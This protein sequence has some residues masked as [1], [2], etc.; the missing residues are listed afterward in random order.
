MYTLFEKYEVRYQ[1]DLAKNKEICPIKC[2]SRE[3]MRMNYI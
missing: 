2:K 1:I 3:M